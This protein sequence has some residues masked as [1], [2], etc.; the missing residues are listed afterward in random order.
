MGGEC[1]DS[2]M[3]IVLPLLQAFKCYRQIIH[4]FSSRKWFEKDRRNVHMDEYVEFIADLRHLF[5]DNVKPALVIDDTVTFFAYCAEVA[6]RENTL[7]VSWLFC[8]CFR[9]VCPLL[10]PVKLGSPMRG[11]ETVDLSCLI[12]AL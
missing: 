8:L 1:F 10:P 5:L 9:R 12:E 7:H 3:L 2:S 11:I 4:S 6:R